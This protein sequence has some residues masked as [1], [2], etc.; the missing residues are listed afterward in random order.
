MPSFSNPRL[1]GAV[2]VGWIISVILHEMGHSMGL[3][4]NFTGSYD[5][6]NYHQE[7]WKLRSRNNTEHYCTAGKDAQHAF[8]GQGCV[9]R[10]SMLH[11]LARQIAR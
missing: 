10:L 7:Y 4:H 5:A 9:E 1:F 11:Q 2:L 8:W 6:L 3:R